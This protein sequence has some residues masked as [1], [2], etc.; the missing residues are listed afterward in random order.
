MCL[1]ISVCEALKCAHDIRTHSGL[2]Q[3]VIVGIARECH[4]PSAPRTK[5]QTLLPWHPDE[6]GVLQQ[7]IGRDTWRERE[8]EE[9]QTER[10]DREKLE[11]ERDREN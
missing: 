9:R 6:P 7:V 1:N 3:Q 4:S 8:K 10:V 2:E 11:R 5:K